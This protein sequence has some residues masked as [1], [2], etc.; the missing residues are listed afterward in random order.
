MKSRFSFFFILLAAF[1]TSVFAQ[2]K[3]S[4]EINWAEFMKRQTLRW[5]TI[6]TSYYGGILLGNGLLG[7]NIYKED[8]QTIRFD[9]GRTD[10]TDQRQHQGSGLSE[11]LISRPRLPIGRM[12]IKTLGKITGAK[13]SLDIYNAT[14]EGTIYTSKGTLKF[15]SFVPANANVIYISAKGTQSEK[16]SIGSSLPKKVKVRG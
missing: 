7:T 16:T 2:L 6:G 3:K 5:D 10:V 11:P 1:T 14:A 4:N 13:M 12:T 8:E 15:S 9:I